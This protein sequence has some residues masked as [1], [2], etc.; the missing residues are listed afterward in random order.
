MALTI[1][2]I[3]IGIITIIYVFITIVIGIKIASKYLKYHKRIFLFIGIAWFG[4]SFPLIPDVLE[5][6]F[7]F[8]QLLL[9]AFLLFVFGAGIDALF[10]TDISNVIARLLIVVSSISFYIGF[11]LPKWAKKV[12]LL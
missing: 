4:M 3:I 9:L 12:L 11:I 6:I 1:I 5:P 2:D 7:I 8:T 10:T